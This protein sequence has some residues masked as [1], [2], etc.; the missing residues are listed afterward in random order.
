[1]LIK[2]I[3]IQKN[4]IKAE[5]LIFDSFYNYIDNSVAKKIAGKFNYF[6]NTR[7]KDFIS[8]IKF[9]YFL[10]Y[11]NFSYKKISIIL[12]DNDKTI[13]LKLKD[14]EKKLRWFLM[15]LT[16]VHFT[17]VGPKYTE[18]TK[19]ETQKLILDLTELNPRIFNFNLTIIL[20]KFKY[21][22]ADFSK[23]DFNALINMILYC[24]REDELEIF[25]I[26][27]KKLISFE[28]FYEQLKD[29]DD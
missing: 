16:V 8:L 29:S 25:L 27:F 7:S 6:L 21:Y 23:N 1:M 22:R 17:D 14:F 4:E 15:R 3:N 18:D 2:V 19:F 5:N 13:T 11:K 10:K 26:P 28:R 9:F 24:N 20:K 12:I